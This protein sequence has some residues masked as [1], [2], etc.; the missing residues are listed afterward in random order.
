MMLDELTTRNGF[1]RL[2]NEMG[3]GEPNWTRWETVRG[4]VVN[5]NPPAYAVRRPGRDLGEM[6]RE[7]EAWVMR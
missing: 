1:G 7:V 6:E 4:Q 5:P 2:V 3:L